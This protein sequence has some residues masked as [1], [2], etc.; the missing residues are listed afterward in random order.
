M[1]RRRGMA[2]AAGLVAAALAMASA[3]AHDVV[4]TAPADDAAASL[5]DEG[6]ALFLTHCAR[7]HGEG[8]E[9]GIG[10]RLVGN[11]R[12]ARP[13]RVATQILRGSIYMPSFATRLDDHE[14]AAIATFVLNLGSND[15][16]I[17]SEADVAALR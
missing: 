6:G 15:F 4:A 7:C 17:V 1:T 12:L 2:L 14:I 5:I 16:G 9:G 3:S 10:P 8:A 13:D 11:A